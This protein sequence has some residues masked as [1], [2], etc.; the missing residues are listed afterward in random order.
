[1]RRRSA[2]LGVDPRT[3][4]AVWDVVVPSSEPLGD[5]S[6]RVGAADGEAGRVRDLLRSATGA[7]AVFVPNAVV[8]KGDRTGLADNKDKDSTLL[9]SLRTPVTLERI[10]STA[11]LPRRHLRRRPARQPARRRSTV[12]APNADFCG[13]TRAADEFEAVMSYYH[14]D[15]TRAYVDSLAL[16]KPLRAQPQVVEANSLPD[17]NSFF[18]PGTRKITFGTGGVD[19]AEDADVIVHEYGHSLQDQAAHF[20]G[21]KLEGASMGEGFGDYMA[22]VMSFQTTGGSPFDPCMFE[23]DATSYVQGNCARRADKA[24]TKSKAQAKCGGDPHCIGLAWSGAIWK[25][26]GELGAR[27]QRPV[28]DGPGRARVALHAQPELEL[29]GRG[30][31]PARGRQAPL[32]GR[33]LRR[34]SRTR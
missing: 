18:S 9:T 4:S 32:R 28:G 10:T 16:T 26:R 13:V 14:I 7:A 22:A 27:H 2:E 34:R 24:L 11:G 8:A 30:K 15:R 25:L 5:F 23:W 17:D 33:A 29:Q 19:D 3:G 12:C 21:E 31:S 20:F 1:M 6:V